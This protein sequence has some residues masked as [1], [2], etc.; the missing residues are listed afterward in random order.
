MGASGGQSGLNGLDPLGTFSLSP[1]GISTLWRTLRRRFSLRSGA[2]VLVRRG[3]RNPAFRCRSSIDTFRRRIET[4]DYGLR[5]GCC[6]GPGGNSEHADC[7]STLDGRGRARRWDD[8]VRLGSECCWPGCRGVYDT[9]VVMIES[10][11]LKSDTGF[12][13]QKLIGTVL[14]VGGVS[15]T[16]WGA[17]QAANAARGDDSR[18]I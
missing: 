7:A 1:T 16:V 8:W 13:F 2:V 14:V 3:N 11:G 15:V 10:L 9:V 12:R 5:R 17:T 6:Q 18:D 4:L